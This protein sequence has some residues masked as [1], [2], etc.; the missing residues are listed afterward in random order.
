MRFDRSSEGQGQSLS[1]P[2]ATLHPWG[3][4]PLYPKP[5]RRER[6]RDW[7]NKAM[8]TW[9]GQ[10]NGWRPGVS[11]K[12]I[13]VFTSCEGILSW[14]TVLGWMGM[15]SPWESSAPRK[16]EPQNSVGQT[17]DYTVWVR[18]KM[19]LKTNGSLSPEN[20]VSRI[21][22]EQVTTPGPIYQTEGHDGH[23]W[24]KEFHLRPLRI[25]SLLPTPPMTPSDVLG[26][27]LGPLSTSPCIHH[28]SW[29]STSA[30]TSTQLLW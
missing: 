10:G 9:K 7:E 27:S 20:G 26:L 4:K 6:R 14:H 1:T 18:Q 3:R 28:F 12:L 16:A 13:T 5:G 30:S 21:P 19:G 25:P 8:R 23:S 22:W 2:T 24:W 15:W 17:L 29:N 11:R